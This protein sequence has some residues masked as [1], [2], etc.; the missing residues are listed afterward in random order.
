MRRARSAEWLLATIT[1]LSPL[2][3][4]TGRRIFPRSCGAWRPAA[5]IAL[6]CARMACNALVALLGALLQAGHVGGG[7]ALAL[8]RPVEEQEVPQVAQRERG[9][10]VCGARD[11]VDLLD[12]AA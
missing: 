5:R 4:K 11:P 3:T 1:S 8:R 6:S 2:A 7:L 10:C 12:P 9:L